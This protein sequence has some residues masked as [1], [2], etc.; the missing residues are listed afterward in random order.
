MAD[1]VGAWLLVGVLTAHG[2][3]RPVTLSIE[4]SAVSTRTFTARAST[5]IDRTE[6][7]VAAHRGLAGRYVDV[8]V[9][10]RCVGN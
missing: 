1:R 7:G 8:S 2:A 9:K 10:V 4:L 6:F 5:C 3:S